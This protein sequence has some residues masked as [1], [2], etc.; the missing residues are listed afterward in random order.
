MPTTTK[1]DSVVC[2]QTFATSSKV[3]ECGAS[4]VAIT[5]KRLTLDMNSIWCLRRM[6]PFC[7]LSGNERRREGR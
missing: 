5:G 2:E 3:P 1:V 7:F 4:Q 6:V